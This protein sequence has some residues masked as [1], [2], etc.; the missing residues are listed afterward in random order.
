MF[1]LQRRV[2][3]GILPL[4]ALFA[5]F[6]VCSHHIA[7]FNTEFYLAHPDSQLWYPEIARDIDKVLS[8]I[9]WGDDDDDN[10]VDVSGWHECNDSVHSHYAVKVQQAEPV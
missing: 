3:S 10:S 6:L 1:I 5:R 4:L 9:M 2:N 7:M 8:V